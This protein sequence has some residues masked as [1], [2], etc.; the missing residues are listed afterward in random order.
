[1][2]D[3][4]KDQIKMKKTIFQKQ[5]ESNTFDHAILSH[6][7]LELSNAISFSKAKYQERLATTL[8]YPKTTPKTYWSILKTFANSSKLPLIPPLLVTDEFV[9]EFFNQAKPV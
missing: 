3:M 7:T 4:I 2:N 5:K 6:I 9:T 8:N 1:M